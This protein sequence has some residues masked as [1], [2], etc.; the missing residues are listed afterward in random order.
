M[1][2]LVGSA[3]SLLLATGLFAQYHGGFRNPHPFAQGTFSNAV[4]GGGV[5]RPGGAGGGQNFRR[6]PSTHGAARTATVVPYGYPVPYAYPVYVGGYVDNDNP[7]EPA[8][9]QPPEQPPT[10]TTIFPSQTAPETIDD[11]GPDNA[12][13]PSTPSAADGERQ[14]VEEP[15]STNEPSH[16]LIAFKD[17]T[18]YAAVAYWVDGDTLHY[19]TSG[20]THNQ[21]SL[22]LID[23]D[24]TERLN[25][26]S[27]IEVK[28]PPPTPIR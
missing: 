24:L 19:F 7:A 14:P 21:V 28:L 27:G 26:E 9:E 23:R 18:V 4:L 22:S 10:S 2:T 25:K 15:A 11:S 1:R 20:N 8:P 5:T 17:H 6:P 16:Y 3:F 12:Q 13:D